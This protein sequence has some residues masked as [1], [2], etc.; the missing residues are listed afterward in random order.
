M[1]FAFRQ[2]GDVEAQ[3]RRIAVEQID[4]SLEEAGGTSGSFGETV[5]R[6][7]RRCKRLRGL[8]RLVKPRFDRFE[9]ENRAFRDLAAALSG[10]RDTAV[11]TETF[12]ALVTYDA[13]RGG[14]AEIADTLATV[15]RQRLRE[16][17]GPEP[18]QAEQQ[19]LLAQHRAG[20]QQ[21]RRRV[22]SWNVRG[23]GFSAVGDGLEATYQRLSNGLDTARA[24]AS[25]EA[26]HAWRKDAKY[27]WHHVSLF[28]EAVPDVLAGRRQLLDRLGELLG[29]HHNLAVLERI[30]GGTSRVAVA[31][32]TPVRSLIAERQA[33]LAGQAFTLG[34]QLTAEK[35][36]TLRA[37]FED[38]WQLLPR[39]G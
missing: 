27:H 7:R 36:A 2:R 26:L 28:E 24:E 15:I 19:L 6:L 3:V 30:L 12:E 18:D 23:K 21:A 9:M 33:T 8:L 20:L 4:K 25:P 1:V 11:T 22:E 39:E 17:V 29:D 13:G 5:H 10:A 34:E 38:Y 32:L 35:P 16:S 37:R 14:D 31:D